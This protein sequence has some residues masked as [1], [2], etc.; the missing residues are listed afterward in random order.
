LDY[1]KDGVM[2]MKFKTLRGVITVHGKKVKAFQLISRV[3]DNK[4]F[5]I[6]K[7]EGRN[8]ILA[9]MAFNR[10][11]HKWKLGETWFIGLPD[12]TFASITFK[13]FD[14]V[15]YR[16][17]LFET[18]IDS[19]FRK[20]S[21]SNRYGSI[22]VHPDNYFLFGTDFNTR[23]TNIELRKSISKLL[24]GMDNIKEIIAGK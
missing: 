24:F 20:K 11:A 23:D 1:E 19:D 3:L 18:G 14:W 8:F 2:N 10:L 21:L 17:M 7:Y 13:V 12:L 6:L 5:L 15:D 4:H 16:A 22:V 9:K